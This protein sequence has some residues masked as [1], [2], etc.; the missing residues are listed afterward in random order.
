MKNSVIFLIILSALSLVVQGQESSKLNIRTID[1]L[2][3]GISGR[4]SNRGMYHEIANAI[5]QEA[6]YRVTNVISPYVRIIFELKSGAADLSILFK[7]KE[8]ESH[9]VYLAPL[10]SLKTVVI[11]LAG[12]RIESIS[13][14]K[15][16]RLGYLRGGRF[17]DAIDND[18][19][20]KTFETAHFRQAV[21]M[22]IN[23]RV[24]A[25]IGPMD[26][27][28]SAAIDLG[29]DGSLFGQPLVVAERTPWVQLSKKSADKF[30]VER[31]R[32]AFNRLN[33]AGEIT[34]IRN[35]YIS[36]AAT[37]LEPTSKP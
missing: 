37:E 4:E 27:I 35:R 33:E 17:S 28:Y 32:S 21:K 26:P 13:Q 6:G 25:I 24:D 10:P 29:R 16:K 9:V 18:P 22:L 1:V 14:L 11:G 31:L 20:I 2:P 30:S 19:D 23:G 5:S 12:A 34:K 15:N 8:L 36:G 3:Y 7:Y